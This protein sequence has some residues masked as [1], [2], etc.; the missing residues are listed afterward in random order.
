MKMFKRICI[1]SF[2][3][4]NESGDLLI[5]ER[6]E[7]H[8]TSDVCENGTIILI[9]ETIAVPEKYFAGAIEIPYV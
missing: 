8:F 2:A 7:E 9:Y 3:V 5:C 4:K 6:G 1:E